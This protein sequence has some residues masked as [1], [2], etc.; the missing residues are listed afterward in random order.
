[1]YALFLSNV[2]HILAFKK[3]CINDG[4]PSFRKKV[5]KDKRGT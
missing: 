2:E 1:M 4:D 3:E 5:N